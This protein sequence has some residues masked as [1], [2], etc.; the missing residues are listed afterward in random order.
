MPVGQSASFWVPRWFHLSRVVTAASHEMDE[1]GNDRDDEENVNQ[2]PRDVEC[3]P[4]PVAHATIRTMNAIKNT[5]RTLG[6]PL[7]VPR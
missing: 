6:S 3:E 7:W 2:A 1:Q 4:M 5:M